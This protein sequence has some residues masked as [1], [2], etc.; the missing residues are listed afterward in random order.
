[1]KILDKCNYNKVPRFILL[2]LISCFFICQTPNSNAATIIATSIV[3][4]QNK[5]NAATS[6]DIIK[7]ANG[8]YTNNSIT[9][10]KSNVIVQAAT[11]GGVYLDGTNAITI[12]GSHV[13]FSG[14]QFTAGAITGNVISVSGINNVITQLNFN[15]YSAQKYIV[16]NAPSQYN[17]VT[18]CNFENKP[19]GAPIGNLIHIDPSATVPGYHKIR[20]CSF[21]N[22]PGLG[23]DNGNECIRISNG[24]TSTYVSRTTIEFCYFNNTGKGDSETISNKCRENVIR[25]NTVVNNQ[26]AW[27]CFRN[28]DN[29]VAY[30]NFFIGAG[31]IRVK[32]A[33]N[34]YCYNNY[35]EN[36]GVGGNADAVTLVYYTANSTNV[37]NNINF[38]HNTFVNCGSIDLGGVGAINN[39][40]A[41]NIFQKSS[42]NI[43]TNANL[44]TTFVGNIYSG[45]LGISIS[46]GM[47]NLNPKLTLNSDSFYGLS[48]SSPAIN[49]S[50]ASYSAILDIANVDDDP[51]ILLDISGQIRPASAIAKDVGCDEYSTGS[52]TIHPLK[53]SEVGPSYLVPIV[54]SIAEKKESN[55]K[56][57]MN[58]RNSMVAFDYFLQ[59]ESRVSAQLYNLDGQLVK[60]LIMNNLESNGA[61]HKTFILSEIPKG[62]YLIR[63]ISNN[64]SQ[65]IKLILS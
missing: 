53:I 8:R 12:S 29:C 25:Y 58:C 54:T 23:G 47:T 1:M 65:T 59:K 31:G 64:N 32:E 36:A 10:A 50:S 44:G 2:G 3:D 22:M 18:F 6:G 52:T 5:I 61:H 14:F 46:S 56:V 24:A 34:I 45:T 19:I 11:L 20:Y 49:A 62:L 55:L 17:E 27:F 28:G 7:L 33:N 21:Q 38:L 40:W 60:T 26:D 43:F 15:G 30:G 48:P 39:L 13:T 57:I 41:N 51:T 4:L 9:I 37:L 63:F 35:F 42:G 16:L